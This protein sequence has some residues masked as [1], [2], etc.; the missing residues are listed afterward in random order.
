[1]LFRWTAKKGYWH[2]PSK[3]EHGRIPGP[4]DDVFISVNSKCTIFQYSKPRAILCENLTLFGSLYMMEPTV[5]LVRMT[6]LGFSEVGIEQPGQTVYLSIEV[7]TI[8]F[9]KAKYEFK[10]TNDPKDP[11]KIGQSFWEGGMQNHIA[12]EVR[13]F[14][15][16]IEEGLFV[17]ANAQNDPTCPF[18]FAKLLPCELHDTIMELFTTHMA[19]IA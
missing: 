4:K 18:M 2:D 17:A 11:F 10:K 5:Q 13:I 12:Q 16:D 7:P 6:E 15:D 3:W 8:D 14:T 9:K 1:M 19:K